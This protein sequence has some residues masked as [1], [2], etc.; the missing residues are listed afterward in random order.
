M[1]ERNDE[2]I[3]AAFEARIESELALGKIAGIACGVFRANGPTWNRGF[4]SADLASARAPDAR[5][6]FRVASIT[7]TVTATAILQLRDQGLLSLDDPL[8]RHLP[9]FERVAVDAG[10]LE[11]VTVRRVLSHFSG[12]VGESPLLRW[13]TLKFP[14]MSEMLAALPQTRIALTQDSHFKY[15]NL[16]YSL[17]GEIVA[18]WTGSTYRDYVTQKIL[19]PLGMNA[20]GFATDAESNLATG[21]M[22]SRHSDGLTP[23]PALALRGM[24]PCGGLWSNVEDMAKWGAA[25]LPNADTG[26]LAKTSI[27]EAHRPCFLEADWSVGY[28]LGW[29]G[30]R[31]GNE[32]F[33]GHGGGLHGYTTMLLYSRTH[34]VGVVCLGNCWPHPGLMTLSSDLLSIM[35]EADRSRDA[36]RGARAKVAD[37]TDAAATWAGQY[38]A[39]PE[40]AVQ[41]TWRNGRL[42]L[43]RSPLSDYTLHAPAELAWLSGTVFEVRGGRAAGERIKFT[44]AAE[45]RA[46]FTLAGWRYRR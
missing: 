20:T 31:F 17:L 29:R 22:S 5:T 34:R 11:A 43:E 19:R 26:V 25:Q 16:G 40:I 14:E 30:A 32:V 24:E 27:D 6:M 4:G 41:V 10:A 9:E 35:I 37:T 13:E 23:A 39:W 18:R 44:R 3:P 1:T 36:A 12:L 2:R 33:H 38:V 15:S 42:W 46:E 8:T 7:K 45:G 21:Y 28:G